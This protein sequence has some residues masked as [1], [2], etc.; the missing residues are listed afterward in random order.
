M[1]KTEIFLWQY[2]CISIGAVVILDSYHKSFTKIV[3]LYFCGILQFI[4]YMWFLFFFFFLLYFGNRIFLCAEKL[5]LSFIF[6][7]SFF[8]GIKIIVT[9]TDHKPHNINIFDLP[10]QVV[11]QWLHTHTH[12]SQQARSI[13][14]IAMVCLAPG[15]YALKNPTKLR[16]QCRHIL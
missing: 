10:D 14:I 8:V 13:H 12:A 5:A 3:I 16:H 15:T 2:I 9:V 1:P 11:L 6:S 7:N 4:F